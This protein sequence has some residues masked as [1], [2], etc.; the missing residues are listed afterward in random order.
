MKWQTGSSMEIQEWTTARRI[1]AMRIHAMWHC[2]KRSCYYPSIMTFYNHTLKDCRRADKRPATLRRRSL[3]LVLFLLCAVGAYGT[4]DPPPMDVD[5]FILIAHRG[6]V[7]DTIPENSLPAL[8][9][10]IRRGYTHMEVDIRGTR[11]GHAVCSHDDSLRR[12]A[13]ISKLISEL[14]LAELRALV[15]MDLVP[16]FATFCAR[17][18][19]RIGV[20][21]DLKGGPPETEEAFVR[22]VETSL[23]KRGLMDDAFFIGRSA[24]RPLF[25]RPARG[26]WRPTLE[27][28][29][30][31]D[32]IKDNP[33]D[34][35]FIFGHAA[36]FDAASV[37]GFQELGLKV[38]VSINIFH[39]LEIG[40]YQ[41]NGDR[42]VARMLAYGVDGLQI[43]NVYEDAFRRAFFG[44]DSPED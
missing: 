6:V 42:D 35:Y 10:S 16:D 18:E 19:G 8:E 3:P 2:G 34:H 33:G 17:S 28:A 22:S 20:M 24:L 1:R 23:V 31:S 29:L 27:E 12:V 5:G 37:R 15:P 40:H 36:D 14:T 7:T 32:R 13:G 43:D 44:E 9:E 25:S 41:E 38:I 4:G 11:D 26:S 39:Y 21:P 30:A